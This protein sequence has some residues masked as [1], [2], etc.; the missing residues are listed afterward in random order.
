VVKVDL[1]PLSERREDIPL[2]IDAFIQ[3]FNAKMGKQITGVSDQTL[4]LLLNYDYPGNVRELENIIEHAFVLC[5]GS[6]IDLDCLPKELTLK[7]K[8]TDLSVSL[9]LKEQ[10]PLGKAE[11]EIV[12][13]TLEK[14]GGS[15]VKAAEELGISRATLWRKIKR[16]GLT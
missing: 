3:K 16:Y 7:Q 8:K 4:R 14:N 12:I 11:A 6:R 13:K 15:R 5:G 2:L 1:P 10:H 9:S